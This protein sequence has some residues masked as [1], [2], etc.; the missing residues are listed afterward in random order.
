MLA[1]VE[2][3]RINVYIEDGRPLRVHMHVHRCYLC[4]CWF[5][6]PVCLLPRQFTKIRVVIHSV[7]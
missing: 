5:N 2:L 3:L 4:E 7:K 6:L 1:H